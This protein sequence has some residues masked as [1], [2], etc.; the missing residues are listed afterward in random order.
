[1]TES[2]VPKG[3]ASQRRQG[4]AVASAPRTALACFSISYRGASA[5]SSDAT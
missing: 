5:A 1:M 3:V 4:L 2:V